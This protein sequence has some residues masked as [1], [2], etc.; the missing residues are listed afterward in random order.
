MAMHVLIPV[1]FI[2]GAI[3][4][5]LLAWHIRGRI[6][7]KGGP[8]LFQTLMLVAATA[9][10]TILLLA[11]VGF[12]LLRFGFGKSGRMSPASTQRAVEDY[13]K[14]SGAREA[15]RQAG[16]PKG[17]VYTFHADGYYKVES[18]LLGKIHRKL[19]QNVPAILAPDGQCWE[20]TVRVFKQRQWTER[21]CKEWSGGFRM[22]WRKS[23]SEM[24]GIK[25]ET[26]QRCLPNTLFGPT[27]KPGGSW[28]TVCKVIS[29]K[30]NMPV[31]M[32]RPDLKLQITH[33]GV[34][35]LNIGGREVA[36]HHLR[37]ESSMKKGIMKGSMV[38][39]VWYAVN[40]GML[41]KLHIKGSGSGL[42][43]FKMDQRFTMA[44]LEPK[45]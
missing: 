23:K 2:V 38:R 33:V 25:S 35:R 22:E 8:T 39:D 20:L 37:Q 21:Y 9:V 24:Y 17:G 44:D 41:L 31:N 42:A 19:P 1:V 45:K 5:G 43:K 29:R 6:G 18:T 36:A 7:H 13:R 4:G 3:A 11:T 34:E 12:G 26:K 10:A 14:A 27:G 30:T 32:P 16:T 40:N 15:S 28:K